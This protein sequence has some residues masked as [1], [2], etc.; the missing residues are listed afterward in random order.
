MKRYLSKTT[1]FI[2]LLLCFA[3]SPLLV[4]AQYFNAPSYGDLVVG[5]RKTG[6]H[7]GTNELVAF[8]TN[9]TNLLSLPIGTTLTMS[10]VPPAR[11]TDSFSSDYTFIQWAV[12]GANYNNPNPTWNTPL[13]NFPPSTI[14][15]TLPRAN[16]SVQTTPKNRYSKG[17]Q[18]G[19]GTSMSSI[20]TGAT[21]IGG[22]LGTTNVDNNTILVRE[23][24]QS[25]YT[26]FLETANMGDKNDPTLGDFGGT[27]FSFSV[28][29]ITP[30]PFTS[31]VRCDL[32]ES[33]PAPSTLPPATYVDPITGSTTS[34]Y[35]VGYFELQPSGTLTFT[36]AAAS[37]TTPPS[38][39]SVNPSPVT[40]SSLSQALTIN[41]ANFVSGCTV[42]LTNTDTS[43]VSSPTVTFNSSSSL[44]VSNVFTTVPHNWSVAVV[45]PDNST[46]GGFPFT[47]V[48]PSHPSMGIPVFNSGHTQITLT[49]TGGAPNLGY[50]VL[51]SSNV[52]TAL[53]LW[54]RIQTNNFAADGSF[55]CSLPVDPAQHQYFF[56]VQP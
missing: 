15:Y 24:V 32:Y 50:Y 45:N 33:A 46:S 3:V 35:F 11:L 12:W 39:T 5:Y 10:N 22:Q 51:G 47:S 13:G 7:Q 37:T 43:A 4:Q 25:A 56:R 8:L 1:R 21:T 34:V 55:S 53:T 27:V 38:V 23:P 48:A 26:A 49:G 17:S 41:G 14:W 16:Q 29:Q 52:T 20:G 19:L 44:T 40:G 6:S 36:R 28:E 42:Y 31:P 9:V 2:V 54:T 18:T 30:S